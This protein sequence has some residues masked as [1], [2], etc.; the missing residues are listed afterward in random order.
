MKKVLMIVALFLILPNNSWAAMTFWEAHGC[1][2]RQ[3]CL[4]KWCPGEFND[5]KRCYKINDF[6]SQGY[7]IT[8][9]EH[10]EHSNT[11]YTLFKKRW[12]GSNKL[13]ICK[14]HAN[15]KSTRCHKP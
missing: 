4:N 2:D 10:G 15:S 8:N 3:E 6:L 7:E 1:K 11:T 9:E 14:V 12:F 13:I 5:G